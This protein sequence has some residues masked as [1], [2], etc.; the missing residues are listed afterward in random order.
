MTMLAFTIGLTIGLLLGF[1]LGMM[2]IGYVLH[3][4]I[5]NHQAEHDTKESDQ[6]E[7]DVLQFQLRDLTHDVA[8][9]GKARH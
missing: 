1:I 6:A 5:R 2:S 3:R 8:F 7:Q 4:L 9:F